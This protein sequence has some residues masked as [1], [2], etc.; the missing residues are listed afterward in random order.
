M[1]ETTNRKDTNRGDRHQAPTSDHLAAKMHETVDRVAD[2]ARNA[3]Q[4]IRSRAADLGER[5]REQEERAL[6]AAQANLQK[7]TS[8][9]QENPLTSAGIAFVAGLLVSGLM[10]R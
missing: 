8:Y 7:A 10:R 1:D 5:A 9:V 3:E 2:T 6:K 4:Q